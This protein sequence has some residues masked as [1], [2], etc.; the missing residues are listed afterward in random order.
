M[1]R[2]AASTLAPALPV[3]AWF[4]TGRTTPARLGLWLFAA[5]L[6]LRFAGTVASGRFQALLRTDGPPVEL[7]EIRIGLVLALTLGY[8]PAC[9]GW[10]V[11]SLRTQLDALRPLFADAG[12]ALEE[13][14]AQAGQLP[15]RARRHALGLGLLSAMTVPFLVDRNPSLYLQ[16]DYWHPEQV[17]NW[18]QL[19][20]IGAI[21]SV[22]M[23]S[24]WEDAQRL[25]RLAGRIEHLDLLDPGALTPFGRQALRIA[26]L[27]VLFPSFLAVLVADQGFAEMILGFLVG[28]AAIATAAFLL[29]VQGIHRRLVAEKQGELARVR[30]AL[31]G[32]V[33]AL[34]GS[35]L[36]SWRS[37]A[38]LGDLL[39]YEARLTA[40]REWPFDAPTLLRFSAFLLLPLGSW[41]GG[42]L[43]ERLVSRILG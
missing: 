30:R 21:V 24:L 29:P 28:G 32:D 33:G 27:T 18:V 39:A 43:V 8:A 42:A 17:L 36:A 38:S 6:L 34:E 40:V 14:H 22:V 35:P 41:L 4:E 37:A 25:T 31:H 9:Y 16:P 12:S 23:R 10:A 13:A 11:R 19:P 7:R 3:L 2:P 1:P 15:I 26:L 20:F 5:M